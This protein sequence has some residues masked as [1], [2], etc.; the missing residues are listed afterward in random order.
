MATGSADGAVVVATWKFGEACVQE[1]VQVLQRGG[2]ALDAVEK[3]A[4]IAE[5]DPGNSSVGLG[6]NPNRDG[7]VQLDA[8]I[9]WGPGHRAGSVAALEGFLHPVSVARR[10]MEV[11]PH[12]MLVGEGAQLFALEQ[13]FEPVE[14]L[15]EES[16]KRWEE[17]KA[18]NNPADSHDTIGVVALD[19]EGNL[20]ASCS[21]SGSG[22]KHPGRVGDSPIIGSGLYVDNEIGAV[23]ATGLGEDI[24]RH[25]VSYAVVARMGRGLPPED[26][27]LEVLGEVLAKDPKGADFST[28]LVAGDR[29][30]RYG[31]AGR[32]KGCP[33]AVGTADRSRVLQGGWVAA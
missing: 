9:M 22:F 32:R 8:A 6:G 12:V 17:W 24:M 19:G 18:E 1:A 16:R 14:L 5:T 29:E 15:T 20:A 21:T 11:S 25:C 2:T 23:A 31:G 28:G 33:Y 30:G 26:A 10:V 13:D 3:G 27:C 7:V 4:G